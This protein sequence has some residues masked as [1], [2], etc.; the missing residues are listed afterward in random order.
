MAPAPFLHCS[1]HENAVFYNGRVALANKQS[2]YVVKL[3][4]TL[5]P[6]YLQSLCSQLR[7]LVQ[8]KEVE[9]TLRSDE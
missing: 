1:F 5:F 8:G 6:F 2:R 9:V 3:Y 4:G 7:V